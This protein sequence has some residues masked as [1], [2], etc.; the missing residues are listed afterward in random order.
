MH[1]NLIVPKQ[2]EAEFK[3]LKTIAV[4]YVMDEPAHL[5]RQD[6]QRERIY[7]VYDY[8]VAGAPGSLD[9]TF[10]LWWEQADTDAAR[11]RAI[12]DQIASMTESR[13][14]RLARRSAELSGFL[15]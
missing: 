1:G 15:S 10:R 6:R 3:L 9:A 11:D 12:I 4:L 2:A 7:R 13:L 14:E 8:L 5:A